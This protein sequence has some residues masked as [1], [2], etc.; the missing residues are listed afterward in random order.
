MVLLYLK[1][2][3]FL[4]TVHYDSH[5][6]VSKYILLQCRIRT[7]LAYESV[8]CSAAVLCP[9]VNTHAA[10]LR[11]AW[12]AWQPAPP[13]H[14]CSVSPRPR[15]TTRITIRWRCLCAWADVG[16]MMQANPRVSVC[17]DKYRKESIITYCLLAATCFDPYMQPK[18]K[19]IIQCDM[20]NLINITQFR[21]KVDNLITIKFQKWFYNL[22]C[23]SHQ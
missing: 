18:L 10:T 1:S 17:P 4:S 7:S 9:A 12:L 13:V 15:R 21:G 23:S 8:A 6:N 19:S 2:V 5:F 3:F 20:R 22:T 11:Y 16:V 14:R